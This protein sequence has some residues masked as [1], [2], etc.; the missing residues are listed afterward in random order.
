[1]AGGSVFH[2]VESASCTRLREFL[3]IPSGL[4][5]ERAGPAEVYP[6]RAVIRSQGDPVETIYLLQSGWVISGIEVPSGARQI[7]K[8]HLPGDLLG[9]PSM[10]LT[11]AAETL[12][13]ATE[14]VVR[15][16]ALDDF[17]GIFQESP[18]LSALMFMASQQER[19]YLM[20]RIVSLGRTPAVSRLAAFLLH[21]YS[22]LKSG[23]QT[24]TKLEIPLTQ[25]HLADILGL[26]PVH[27]NRTYRKIEQQGAI[28]RSGRSVTILDVAALREIAAVPDRHWMREPAWLK[29][30]LEPSDVTP[31]R[32]VG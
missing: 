8:V 29:A 28:L 21:I 24:P 23:A 25:D 11:R 16:I 2:E 20:D 26:T 19:V 13:A 9:V 22:R 10:V 32:M 7:V 31:T 12:T 18:S 6:K 15:R 4:L 17:A 30:A 14:V 27:I 5:E 1:M 3:D